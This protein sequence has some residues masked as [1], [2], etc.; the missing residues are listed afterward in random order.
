MKASHDIDKLIQNSMKDYQPVPSIESREKFLLAG[1]KLIQAK[2]STINKFWRL[3]AIILFISGTMTFILLKNFHSSDIQA[4]SEVGKDL[5]SADKKDVIISNSSTKLNKSIAEIAQKEG[6]D[7]EFENISKPI[8]NYSVGTKNKA[9][10][11]AG[12]ETSNEPDIKILQQLDKIQQY[13]IEDIFMYDSIEHSEY[14][15]RNLTSKDF[16]INTDKEKRAKNKTGR[17]YKFS[18]DVYYMPEMVYN[19]IDTKKLVNSFGA[20]VQFRFF[21]NRYVLLSGAGVSFS[22]GYYEYLIDYQKYL[23]SYSRLDSITFS[24]AP[25]NFHLIPSYYH[26]VE[27]VYDST[28][29]NYAT[30]YY[31]KFTYLQIPVILGYDFVNKGNLTFSVRTGPQLSILVN[32]KT[33]EFE[34]DPGKDKII[35]INKIEPD[36]INLNW[37]YVVG[38]NARYHSG[39]HL[40]FEIE[41]RFTYY[42]NSVYQHSNSTD[43]PFGLGLRMA[44]GFD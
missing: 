41:P 24:L 6:A 2:N 21:N 44:I 15:Y 33:L 39:K 27:D 36:R 7:N 28:I 37:Q 29:M 10:S 14:I 5:I 30:N 19:I 4:E 8:S 22:N 20:E 13:S 9:I 34:Y 1:E 12:K 40:F 3:A 23:G 42:F 18:Y 17:N 35:Q 11:N 25:D 16:V 32:N 26:S 43:P 38:I 31:K